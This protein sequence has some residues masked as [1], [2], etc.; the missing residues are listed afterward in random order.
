MS[1]LDG[2]KKVGLILQL[3]MFAVLAF[4]LLAVGIGYLNGDVSG[5]APAPVEKVVDYEQL[6]QNCLASIEGYKD[7][8]GTRWDDAQQNCAMIGAPS[9]LP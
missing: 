4:I 6:Y 7:D 2:A 8:G 3:G 5:P 1:G 9:D